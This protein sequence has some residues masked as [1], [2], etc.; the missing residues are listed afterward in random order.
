M[1]SDLTL[2]EMVDA[3]GI[4]ARNG[5]FVCRLCGAVLCRRQNLKI[6][7]RD[8]HYN[9]KQYQCPVCQKIYKN[10][11]SLRVH[12]IAAHKELKGL[13]LEYCAI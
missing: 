8:L 13:D 2:D 9:A 12:T 11:S 6:H 1:L 3:N 10:K 4:P 5:S 7:I